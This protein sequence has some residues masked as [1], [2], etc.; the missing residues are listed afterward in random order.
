MGSGHEVTAK[1]V[2]QAELFRNL[3]AISRMWQI[4][5]YLEASW[6]S[7]NMIEPA[8]AMIRYLDSIRPKLGLD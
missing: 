5:G 7:P 3:N 6:A 2:A 4:M 8:K 1:A